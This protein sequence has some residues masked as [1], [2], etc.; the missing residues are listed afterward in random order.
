[1]LLPFPPG[2]VNSFGSQS[3]HE[4]RRRASQVAVGIDISL[5]GTALTK[6]VQ[7]HADRLTQ[8]E[9]KL[10][11]QYRAVVDLLNRTNPKA[12][13]PCLDFMDTVW[14]SG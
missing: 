6:K 10:A 13:Q 8:F 2:G 7:S 11:E 1:M 3:D 5:A 12:V 4:M 14:R 9:P